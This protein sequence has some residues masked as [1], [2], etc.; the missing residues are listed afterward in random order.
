VFIQSTDCESTY[1]AQSNFGLSVATAG[2]FDGDGFDDVLA[3]NP[4]FATSGL[5]R[6]V[7]L[8][9]IPERSL[10]SGPEGPLAPPPN[11]NPVNP[12][13][14]YYAELFGQSV[15]TAGDLN[16]DGLADIVI[17]APNTATVG[18]APDFVGAAYVYLGRP[19]PFGPPVASWIQTGDVFSSFGTSV[20]N[21]GD[22]NGDG[23]ADVLVGAPGD[24]VFGS[25][26]GAAFVF[27]GAATASGIEAEPPCDP[28][29]VPA[30][31]C[32]FGSAP[33][34]HFG[35]SVA[36]AGDLNGDGYADAVFGMP[37]W[38]NN[39]GGL[40]AVEILYGRR[41]AAYVIA[42][43]A[44]EEIMT[45]ELSRL[46]ATVAT[47]GDTDGD[48]FSEIVVG[49]PDHENGETLEG[50]AALYKGSGNIPQLSTS[51][52]FSP[53]S[54]ARAGDSIATADVNGDGRSDVIVGAP[55]FDNGLP[56]QGAV[57]VFNTP[58]SV[59]SSAPPPS[60]ARSYFGSGVNA[61]FGQSVAN[62]GDVND[63][64]FED[65]IVGAPGA[66][67]AYLFDGGPSGLPAVATQDLAGP[68]AGTRFGQSVTGAGD[69]NGDGLGD[70]VIGAPLDETSGALAD[71][72]I[73]RLYLGSGG[74]SLVASTWSA[75]SGQAGAQLG[76]VVSGAGDVNRDGYS[77]VLVGAPH[78]V[79]SFGPATDVVGRV[80]LFAGSTAGLSAT[81]LLTV[82]GT[83][84]LAATTASAKTSATSATSTRTASA[85]SG[86]G[87]SSASPE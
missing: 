72:G 60:P 13:D 33:G 39:L 80:D 20:A 65:V 78:F 69:V 63:D 22:L 70:V 67:H 19:R 76:S 5:G 74:G 46:G 85:T 37:D 24:N 86:S 6:R 14:I 26:L 58:I 49:A 54:F 21:A 27:H 61:S 23:F 48:G 2:D 45:P 8:L 55:H 87:R 53:A 28:T 10:R 17:G 32:A 66:G 35:T 64:G 84:S 50:L 73:A 68:N 57:F 75:H 7:H 62:A 11:R 36:T 71:E 47:G 25:Q 38:G 4:D 3:P 18:S 83:G 56:D 81:P 77:D 44:S 82:T 59:L 30:K 52:H 31:Y 43:P 41:S 1:D 12:P 9:R 42:S 15:S 40:G 79:A 34:A 51:W 16:G 29:T